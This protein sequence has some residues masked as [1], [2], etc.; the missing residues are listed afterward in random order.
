MFIKQ[1]SVFSENKS[2]RIADIIGILGDCGIDVSALSVAD[3]TDFGIVR[4]IVSD[5]K[6]AEQVLRESGAVVKVTDVLGV[7]VADVPGG[8]AA[9]LRV[10]KD[11][12]IEID[13]IYAFVGKSDKGALVVMKVN[14]PEKAE[15]VFKKNG[16]DTLAP[17]DV[18]RV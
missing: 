9:A 16:I 12:S 11:E 8:L 3:T 5:Y 18:Y 6:K 14:D 10:L 17:E 13:Y 7:G 4:M 1:V 15:A 2:G